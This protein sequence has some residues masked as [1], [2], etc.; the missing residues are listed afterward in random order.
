MRVPNFLIRSNSSHVP[1]LCHLFI[2]MP[3]VEC[4][5]PL[6]LYLQRPLVHVARPNIARNYTLK[7]WKE[8]QRKYHLTRILTFDEQI[9]VL[10]RSWRGDISDTPSNGFPKLKGLDLMSCSVMSQSK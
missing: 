10:E 5:C 6:L 2:P 4:P 9:N 8:S 3:P 7:V 1:C